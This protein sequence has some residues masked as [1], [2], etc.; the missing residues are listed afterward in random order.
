MR[1][2]GRR[3]TLQKKV[4]STAVMYSTYRP[5]LPLHTLLYTSVPK[6]TWLLPMNIYTMLTLRTY[7]YISRHPAHPVPRVDD[8]SS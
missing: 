2:Y 4:H 6:S 1:T 5:V 7:E 3:M 8:S